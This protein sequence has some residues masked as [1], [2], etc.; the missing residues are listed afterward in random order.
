V[1][2]T[3]RAALLAAT[4]LALATITG[5]SGVAANGEPLSFT[6]GGKPIEI[7]RFDAPLGGRRPTV[8]L[9]HGADGLNNAER[10]R[11]GGRILAAA[12]YNVFFVHYLG[13]TDQSRAYYQ[14]IARH[15]PAWAETVRDALSFVARQPGVDANR[16]GLVGTSLGGALAIAVAADDRRV[17]A[18]V[19]YFGFVPRGFTESATRLPPTLVMHGAKD[20]IVPVSNAYALEALLKRLGAPHEV[21]VYPDQ[22]HGLY[23]TAQIDAAQRTAT[24][25]NRYLGGRAA[26][27][28]PEAVA[29]EAE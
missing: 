6:S 1:Q 10:Y 7:E 11:T 8:L 20:A 28:A 19:D 25:L 26:S 22:A 18:V 27:L 4:S 2:T 21:V 16:L 3:R 24:F 9:L 17:K 29:N 14:T 13:R 12:G 23:G 5:G 15:F